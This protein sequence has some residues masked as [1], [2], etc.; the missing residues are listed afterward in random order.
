MRNESS[1]FKLDQVVRGRNLIIVAVADAVL[2]SSRILRT[3]QAI[4]T[5]FATACPM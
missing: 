2:S 5:G 3:E 4:N 1:L